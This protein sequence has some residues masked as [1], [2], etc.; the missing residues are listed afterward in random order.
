MRLLVEGI[1][2]VSARILHAYLVAARVVLDKI[3]EV[4]HLVEYD[5]PAVLDGAMS[6]HFFERKLLGLVHIHHM[7]VFRRRRLKRDLTR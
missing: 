3:G 7:L 1:G 5:H 6:G 4:V 2:G